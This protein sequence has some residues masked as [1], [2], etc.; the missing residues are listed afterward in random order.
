MLKKISI[1]HGPLGTGGEGWTVSRA[2]RKLGYQSDHIVFNK[3]E[4]SYP[5]DKNLNF[6]RNAYISNF[7]KSLIFLFHAL[8]KYEVFHFYYAT[9]L[10]PFYLDLPLLKLFRKKIFFTFQGCDIRN[11]KCFPKTYTT[12]ACSECQNK[13]CHRWGWLKILRLKIPLLFA[14]QTFAITPDLKLIS[15]SS[16][17]ITQAKVNFTLWQPLPHTKSNQIINIIHAPTY[18]SIK[19]TKYIITAI[20]ALIK[21]GYPIKLT[22]IENIPHNQMKKMCQEAD[23]AID[24]LLIGWYG[25]YAVEMMALEKPVICY[26]NP[27]LFRFVPWAKEIPIINATPKNIKEKIKLLLENPALRIKLGQAGRQFALK[28]HNPESLAKKFIEYYQQ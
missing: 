12:N 18:R 2:E 8:K 27:D 25:G 21:E 6:P 17:I 3:R 4:Y 26:L 7:F 19:G 11:K 16:I 23:I 5:A 10:L 22:T 28:Y 13:R 9:S 24:Q 15:P 14:N 20:H 1:F